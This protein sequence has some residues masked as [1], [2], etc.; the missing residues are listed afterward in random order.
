M[1]RTM[2]QNKNVFNHNKEH[3][4][5]RNALY[6]QSLVLI[7]DPFFQV[8]NINVFIGRWQ[9]RICQLLISHSSCV[10]WACVRARTCVC[11]VL[12]ACNAVL[13]FIFIDVCR[14]LSFQFNLKKSIT[15]CVFIVNMW[16]TCVCIVWDV[17]SA[18]WDD[19]LCH[20]TADGVLMNGVHDTDVF[21]GCN[22]GDKNWGTFQNWRN[23][24]SRYF[25]K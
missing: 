12:T 21:T 13:Q 19:R 2:H 18:S 6:R 7:N 11:V 10:K 25:N 1:D 9:R 23:N 8:E 3:G 22:S 5:R 14:L 16:M 15:L 17:V 4:G 24:E 20:Y